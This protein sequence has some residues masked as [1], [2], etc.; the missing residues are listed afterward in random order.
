MGELRRFRSFGF[1]NLRWQGIELRPDDI[2]I[3]TPP[4]CGTTWTQMMCALLIF[5]TTTLDRPLTQISPWIENQ[6]ESLE[7][8]AATVDAQRHRR[9][10]KSH[11]PFD[12]LPNDPNVKYICVARDPRDVAVSWAHHEANVNIEKLINLRI[13]AVG[14]DDLDE[15][16]PFVPPPTDPSERFWYWI[17]DPAEKLAAS[18]SLAST[19]YHLNT[20]WTQRYED[21]LLLL[22]YS[23]LSSDLDTEM[24]RLAT[25]L[26]I[27]VPDAKWDEL[28]EAATFTS[29]R[30]RSKEL[31]PEVTKGFWNADVFF[32]S[33]SAG[34]WRQFIDTEE[35]ASRYEARVAALADPEFAR[36]VH[37]GCGAIRD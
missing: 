17:D 30:A 20:F 10:L 34:E 36:W 35:A 5:Q 21:N 11:T 14:I 26:E 15:L 25:F 33:G 16:D 6:T 24:R 28:V 27:E 7:S 4:K 22:H 9:F 8:V 2:I 3:S 1:D 37:F 19:L 32:R 13:E 31:T 29:M 12:F 18:S 23:D